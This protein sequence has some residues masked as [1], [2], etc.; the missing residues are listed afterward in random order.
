MARAKIDELNILNAPSIEDEEESSSK[1]FDYHDFITHYFDPMKITDK[2]K[3]ERIEA[4]EEL[5]DAI[6]LFFMWC[7]NAPERVQEE[8]T[9][10]SFENMYKE[11][12]FQYAEPDDYLDA[13]VTLF[14]PQLI[15]VTLDHKGEDYFTSVERAAFNAA[16]ES[17]T[18]FNHL[19][20]EKAKLLGFK[21]K[22]WVAELDDR[23][24]PDHVEMNGWTVP[25]D[26]WFV[27]EDCMMRFP[28]DYING[29]MRQLCNCRC[30]LKFS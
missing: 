3:K 25:I 14:I 22:T 21:N 17:N 23:T 6:L 13:Y 9:Q 16:N 19:D 5:F 29:T 28:H 30:S 10:R 8:A 15:K 4:A 20:L 2:Q 12:L 1:A 24:R 26:D 7:D 27:F 11:V 18:L